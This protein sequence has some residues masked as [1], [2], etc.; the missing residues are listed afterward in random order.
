M[1][2]HLHLLTQGLDDTSHLIKFMQRFKRHTSFHFKQSSGDRLWQ[3]SYFD[4]V[5]RQE[6]DL[7]EVANYVLQNPVTEGLC[8]R[9]EDYLLSGGTFAAVSALG[10]N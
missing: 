5:L 2:D 7:T 8:E 10:P 3:S 9:P 1:P 4:R 6:E